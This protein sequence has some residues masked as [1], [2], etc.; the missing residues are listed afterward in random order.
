[1][2]TLRVLRAGVALSAPVRVRVVRAGVTTTGALTLRVL[3]AGVTTETSV[4][5]N[6]GVPVT[7]DSLDVVVLSANA[8]SGAPRGTRGRRPSARR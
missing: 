8:S 3:R 2:A 7:V 4:L 1:M 6:A 5:A